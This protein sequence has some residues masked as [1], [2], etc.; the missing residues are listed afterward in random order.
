MCDVKTPE[1]IIS[2]GIAK[3]ENL[4][5]CVLSH[6]GVP[7]LLEWIENQ[8]IDSIDS[9]ATNIQ[10]PKESIYI[11]ASKLSG[12][13]EK[14]LRLKYNHM[15]YRVNPWILGIV[16]NGIRNQDLAKVRKNERDLRNR[17]QHP[18]NNFSSR[19]YDLQDAFFE[20]T[21]GRRTITKSG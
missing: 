20:E 10:Y 5:L 16:F 12:S 11:G 19:Y 6:S 13:T 17:K 7:Q 3:K 15:V 1:T 9:Y 18:V 8:S 4:R 14:S 2:A 21:Y